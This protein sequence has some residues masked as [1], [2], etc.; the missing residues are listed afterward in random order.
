MAILVDQPKDNDVN[1]PVERDN[2]VQVDTVVREEFQVPEKFRGK[3]AEE[4]ARSYVELEKEFGRVRNDVGEYRSLTDR[5]LQLEE[6]RAK[7]L[8]GAGAKAEADFNID[9][10]ELL[11]NP[12][13]SLTKWYEYQKKKDPE[14][15]SL[16]ERLN[17]IEGHVNTQ[18]MTSKH[19][20]AQEITNDP[21]F[22]E[23]VKAHP[24]RLSIAQQAVQNGNMDALDYL[25]TE[26]KERNATSQPERK[27]VSETEAAR[28]VATEKASSGGPASSRTGGDKVFSRRKL[29]QLKITNPEEYSAM[30]DQILLAYAQGRVVD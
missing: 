20:D 2:N 17:R 19:A 25:L 11:S 3:S 21:R 24:V 16:Q 8:E 12:R 14:F 6:K 23:F 15:Q 18:V 1:E 7:D 27:Q 4:I 10:A 22:H 30:Q 13:E 26:Y 29:I 5:L 28:R 9:P